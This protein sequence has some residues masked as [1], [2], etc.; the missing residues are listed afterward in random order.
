[1]LAV[2]PR[3]DRHSVFLQT[4]VLKGR[5]ILH[6]D[7]IPQFWLKLKLVTKII[8]SGCLDTSVHS[9]NIHCLSRNISQYWTYFVGI[10]CLMVITL[11]HKFDLQLY[12]NFIF[13]VSTYGSDIQHLSIY[14]LFRNIQHVIIKYTTASVFPHYHAPSGLMINKMVVSCALFPVGN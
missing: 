6:F 8:E 11:Q 14:R 2:S 12:C 3:P 1:M 5:N 7:H 9:C 13:P 4:L 10:C